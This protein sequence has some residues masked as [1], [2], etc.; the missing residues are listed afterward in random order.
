MVGSRGKDALLFGGSMMCARLMLERSTALAW[1]P[2]NM[3]MTSILMVLYA[4]R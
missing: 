2:E 4:A 1:N 3:R